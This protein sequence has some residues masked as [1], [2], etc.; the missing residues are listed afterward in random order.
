M[1]VS[2]DVRVLGSVCEPTVVCRYQV[3]YEYSAQ[4]VSP[5]CVSASGDVRVLGSVCE[6]TVVCR[7]QVMYE[8]SAQFVS[9]L[10][11]VGVR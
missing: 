9:P 8:Y 3:M 11:C 10:W 1:S 2:G 5:L 4:F 6:P 7:R